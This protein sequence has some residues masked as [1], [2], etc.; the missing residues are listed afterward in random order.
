MILDTVL[1]MENSIDELKN[2]MVSACLYLLSVI[3][4]TENK[5][6]VFNARGSNGVNEAQASSTSPMS[7]L[8]SMSQDTGH[9]PTVSNSRDLT[10]SAVLSSG[11]LSSAES[12]L[13]WPI[14]L[15]QPS[16]REEVNKSLLALEYSR[17]PFQNARYAIFPSVSMSEVKAIVSIFQQTYNFWFP[18]MSLDNLKSIQLRISHEDLEPSSQSCLSLLVMAL[19]CIG[20]SVIDEDISVDESQKLKQ[21]GSAWFNA[22]MKMLHL[23]HIEMSVEACQCLLLTG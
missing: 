20:A 18:T 16:I 15:D 2:M 13:K 19:G 7:T 17:S 23:A 10:E 8:G 11:H 9:P 6:Q 14:F 22:A 12:L 3:L 1:R 5:S 4:L 21:R